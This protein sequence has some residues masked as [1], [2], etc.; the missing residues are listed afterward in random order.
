M[1]IY[2]NIVPEH[3]VREVQRRTLKIIANALSQSF[4]PK[5]SITTIV[6]NMDKN[7]VNIIVE[8][9]KDG[10]TIVKNILFNDSIERSVQDALT[11]L[12]RYIVKM[13]GDGTTSAII[14]CNIVFDCLCD[15]EALLEAAPSDILRKIDDIIKDACDRIMSRGHECT[16]DDIYNIALISTNNNEDIAAT[17][18]NVYEEFGMEVFIDVGISNTTDNIV[19]KYDGMTMDV[20]YTNPCFINMKSTN[21]SIV[22][23]PKIYC[24][25]DNIDT[26]EMANMVNTIIEYNIIRAYY[27]DSV[28]EPTPTVIFCKKISPDTASSFER[29]V[30]LMNAVPDVPLL[31]V[32]DVFQDEMYEDI[33]KMCG[34]PFI[35][36][37]LNPDIQQA[38]IDAGRAPTRDT[39]LDFCGHAE[40]VVADSMKTKI[41]NPAMMFNDDRTYSQEYLTMMAYLETEVQKCIDESAGVDAI[42]KAKRRLNSFKGNMVDFLVGGLTQTDRDNLKGSVEDAVLNCRSAAVN[43]VGYGANFMA[44]QAFNEMANEQQYAGDTIVTTMQ[45]AYDGLLR[46]LYGKSMNDTEV[47]EVLSTSLSLGKPLNIRTNEYDGKVLSSIKS[48]VIILETISKILALMYTC[49]Q[50][51]VQT[52]MHN[53]YMRG[54]END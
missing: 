18:K 8:K 44:Y 26:P 40:E 52:P 31:I 10:H 28:Y 30:S 27:K 24:F 42:S 45:K 3:K 35:K 14:L 9:T 25:R 37:Y 17:L 29:V 19:K 48:D 54:E 39:I 47:S 1:V 38:D 53:V 51:L 12:T 21:Q 23:K 43:G 15:N 20:G 41:I 13:V 7:G 49:N 36:K 34:A 50:Y 4:G 6:K 32:S 5:G 11:E 16:M 22:R 46:E 33:A 2:S